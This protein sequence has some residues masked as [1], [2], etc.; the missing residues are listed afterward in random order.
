MQS[1]GIRKLMHDFSHYLKE[2]KQGECITILERNKPVADIVPH[3]E[4]IKY[5]GWRR[6][7]KRISIS[8]EALSVTTAKNRE[9][10]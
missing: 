10:E 9:L 7:I 5:P 2:V 4:N 1:I 8:G 3:R 6:P